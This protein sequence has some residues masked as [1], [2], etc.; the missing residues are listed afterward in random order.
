MNAFLQ[1][2]LSPA[3]GEHASPL[4][5]IIGGIGLAAVIAFVLV[6][7][8]EKK[9][10]GAPLPPADETPKAEEPKNEDSEEA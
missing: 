9:K 8:L 5:W 3:T 2:I 4:P 6:A 1:A 10:N 7:L